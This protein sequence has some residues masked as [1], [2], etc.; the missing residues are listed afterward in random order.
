[1]AAAQV[2]YQRAGVFAQH[3][4]L[5][6]AAVYMGLSDTLHGTLL[7]L[8]V[9]PPGF[10]AQPCRLALR[11]CMH[12]L[13]WLMLSPSPQQPSAAAKLMVMHARCLAHVAY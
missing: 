5:S 1:M 11:A 2:M 12:E 6:S 4:K 9:H 8:D 10:R 3:S 13:L 7:S